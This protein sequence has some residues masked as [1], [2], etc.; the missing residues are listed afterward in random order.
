MYGAF[1]LIK[2]QSFGYSA[3]EHELKPFRSFRTGQHDDPL[4][5]SPLWEPP[6]K[7]FQVYVDPGV[8]KRLNLGIEVKE[9]VDALP[10]LRFD[11]FS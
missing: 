6:D 2:P 5:A 1:V 7:S 9:G 10:Q 4:A 11:L 8:W 3:Q